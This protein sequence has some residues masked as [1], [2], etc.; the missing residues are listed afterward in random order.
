[1]HCWFGYTRMLKDSI[2]RI[3]LADCTAKG[4]LQAVVDDYKRCP[5]DGSGERF[6]DGLVGFVRNCAVLV[7]HRV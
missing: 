1:M 5:V 6:L 7:R 3:M 2:F 4:H